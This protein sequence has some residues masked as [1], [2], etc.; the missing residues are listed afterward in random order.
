[1]YDNFIAT[2]IGDVY[3]KSNSLKD[4]YIINS[5]NNNKEFLNI[6]FK[7]EN[8]FT[9]FMKLYDWVQIS[10]LETENGYFMT[11]ELSDSYYGRPVFKI[12][13]IYD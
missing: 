12:Y 11:I 10:V 2:P 5:Y 8:Q 1:M 3:F 9:K 7:D 6:D 4:I 13:T